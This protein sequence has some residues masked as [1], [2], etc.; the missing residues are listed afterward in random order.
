MR[1]VC[2]LCVYVCIPLIVFSSVLSM[3]YQRKVGDYFFPELL[4]YFFLICL[5]RLLMYECR[6]RM[7]QACAFRLP[8]PVLG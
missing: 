2:C 4:V 6:S 8:I 7:R 1:S 5:S 3:S